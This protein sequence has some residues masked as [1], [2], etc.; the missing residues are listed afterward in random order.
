MSNV[1]TSMEWVTE[2]TDLKVRI[3]GN[4]PDTEKAAIV[5]IEELKEKYKTDDLMFIDLIDTTNDTHVLRTLEEMVHLCTQEQKLIEKKDTM[6]STKSGQSTRQRLNQDSQDKD[7]KKK[8]GG[9]CG[10]GG[11]SKSKSS[12][13]SGSKKK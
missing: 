10:G 6:D 12:K 2:K 4:V 5:E 8:K 11:S 3:Y 7:T 13:E 1:Q 9:C